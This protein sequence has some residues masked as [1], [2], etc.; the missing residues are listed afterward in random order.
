MLRKLLWAIV[1]LCLI[2]LVPILLRQ[3]HLLAAPDADRLV[4]ITPH[5][6]AIRFEFEHAF[7][8]W[9]KAQ[10][11]REV[12]FDWRTPGGTSEIVR[13][14]TGEYTAGFRHA[15][16]T[17][18]H[19]W[20][21]AIQGG[22]LDRK[23]KAANADP[24]AWEAR[25]AFL[26]GDTSVGIDLFF[27]GGQYDMQRLAEAG[28]L[29]PCGL[30]NRH[31]ELFTGPVPLVPQTLGGET[32]YD[33][34]DRYYGACLAAFGI[35]YNPQKVRELGAPEP[36]AWADLG[37][38]HFRGNLGMG[39]PSKSGSIAKAFEMLIQEQMAAA[40]AGVEPKTPAYE[41]ALKRGWDNAMY[42]VRRLGANARYF[43]NAA[44]KVSMDVANG[45]AAAGMV[46]DVY[47]RFQAEWER[48][49]TGR[50]I[51]KYVTPPGGSSVSADPIALLRGAP[52]TKT[53][54]AFI[55]F[56]LSPEG[57]RL[58]NGRIGSPGGPVRYALRRLPIRRDLYTAAER[59]NM[60]E[61]QE[62][63]F[64]LAAGF[65]YHPEWTGPL[66]NLS[67]LFIRVMVIDC[68]AELRE[69]W[70]A[71]LAA[72]GPERVPEAAACLRRLP[73]DY[74]QAQNEVARRLN[75]NRD[76]VELAREWAAFFRREYREAARLAR[77]TPPLARAP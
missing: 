67:R 50:E 71:I 32:W 23:L 49:E 54:Q 12:G 20:T 29:V 37:D 5:N 65:T 11:G 8:V 2:L 52:H 41:E 24:A 9:Y 16:K 53:A 27:G 33:P 31:P 72:G 44:G 61:L 42:L 1:P 60:C 15:W 18:G 66:F 34:Q 62:D 39:D 73:F 35:C 47:G 55:D 69:A 13:H 56:V 40:V 38:P 75:T 76:A 10:T 59:E 64:Q 22:L 21:S 51:M 14:L 68:H 45:D 70:E 43:T 7:T 46:I 17:A 74:R 19:A 26:T 63:P 25:Q 58:W 77:E 4:I 30:R 57:Q 3:R 28:I 36:H 6:E 48:A